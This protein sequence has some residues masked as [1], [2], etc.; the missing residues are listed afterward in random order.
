MST[1]YKALRQL[2]IEGE[3]ADKLAPQAKV[4]FETMVAHGGVGAET[5]GIE[6]KALVEALT[7][8]GKLETRQPAERI[9][10][11][12][13]PKL[14]E[15]GLVV[16]TKTGPDPKAEGEKATK[17]KGGKK[18]LTKVTGPTDG[19]GEAPAGEV[20]EATVAL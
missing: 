6:R 1:N 4:V 17:P 16:I 3:N 2:V 12:Y 20:P 11:Y 7:N 15:A 19:E 13:A 14:E 8:E 5:A 10:S 9:L 18:K